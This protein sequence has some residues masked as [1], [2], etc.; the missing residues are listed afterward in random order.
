VRNFTAPSAH[1]TVRIDRD[2]LPRRIQKLRAL[3][4]KSKAQDIVLA[5]RE[6][7]KHIERYYTLE[8]FELLNELARDNL[9]FIEQLPDVPTRSLTSFEVKELETDLQGL[10]LRLT[11]ENTIRGFF[12]EGIERIAELLASIEP[13]D[14]PSLYTIPLYSLCDTRVLTECLLQLFLKD[15]A[16]DSIRALAFTNTMKQLF[17]NLCAVSKITEHEVPKYPHKLINP[18]DS[19]FTPEECIRRYLSNTPFVGYLSR[20]CAFSIPDRFLPEHRLVVASTGT[21]KSQ[22]IQAD[23][24]HYL[25]RENRPSIVIIDSM[26][27]MLPKFERLNIWKDDLIIIDPTDINPPALSIFAQPKRIKS[28]DANTQ[29]T[30]LSDTIK[31]FRFLFGAL[32]VDLSGR[33]SIFFSFVMRLIL[34]IP[35]ASLSHLFRLLQEEPKTAQASEFWPYIERMDEQSRLFFEDRF[36]KKGFNS[37]TKGLLSDRIHGITS[38]PAFARMLTAKENKLDLFEAINSGKTILVNTAKTFLGDAFPI[39]G[40]YFIASTLGAAFQRVALPEPYPLTLLYVDEAS[41][42]MQDKTLADLFTKARQ[43]NLG[44]LVAYQSLSQLGDLRSDILTN[45]STKL[46]SGIEPKEADGIDESLRTSKAFLLSLQKND[47]GSEFAC[48]VKGYTPS[49]VRLT[50]PF[51]V[52]EDAPQMTKEAHKALRQRNRERYG[53]SSSANVSRENSL[54]QTHEAPAKKAPNEV[55]PL[56][57]TSVSTTPP[58]APNPATDPHAGIDD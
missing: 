26:G 51:G 40:R 46:I 1:S 24:Y 54:S 12:L 43:F 17:S 28:Y 33:Q 55:P 57:S 32:D 56:H 44:A 23:V 47:K 21:G 9:F 25:Q 41:E 22:L 10:T 42:Y 4:D 39:F 50:I 16:P 8:L 27:R 5:T 37:E 34:S 29:A 30:I 14:T 11:N 7:Y 52:I 20:N 15:F 2:P 58:P 53:T 49:A 3:Y 31:L 6:M 13:D 45:T 36:F 48:Y 38:I 35:D 18:T 19:D